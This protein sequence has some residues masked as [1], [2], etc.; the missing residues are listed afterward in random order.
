[1]NNLKSIYQMK[2]LKYLLIIPVLFSIACDLEEDPPFLDDTLYQD[3][4]SAEAARDG[5]YQA[6][7][8]YNT[9][10]RRLFI[11]NLYSGIMFTG[12]GGNRVT[13]RDMS[14]LCSLKPGLHMD[15]DFMWQGL[16]QAIARANGAIANVQIVSSPQ[17]QDEKA[18]NDVAGHAYFVRAWAYFRLA[19][20]WGD[21]PLWLELPSQGN[22]NK[23][24]SPEVDI[25]NQIIADLQAASSLLNGNAGVGY[26]KQYA[27]NMLL[28][29]VY[30]AIATNSVLQSAGSSMDYWNMAYNEGVKAYGQY[31]L[32]SDY[33]SLFTVQ[34]ENSSES[35]FE[36][37]ISQDAANSQM[38]RNFT[39]W[40][41]KAGMHF[42]W[43]RVTAFHHDV[44][45]KTYGAGQSWNVNNLGDYPDKRYAATYLYD[46]FR[47]DRPA[48]RVRT[49][50]SATW[51]SS[52]GNS[53]PYLF[54]WTEK[55][56]THSNQ[57]NSQNIVDMRYAE[58]LLMLAEISNEI[59]NG[60]EMTYL[61]PVLDRAGVP[62]R[63]EFTSGQ[64]SFRDAIM[65]EYKFEL[66]GEGQDSF[67]NRRRGL[68]Y[69]LDHTIL[70]HNNSIGTKV[71]VG[72]KKYAANRE[73]IF[74]TDPNQIMK[75]QIPL[76]EINT[77]ELIN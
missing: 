51:R 52:F 46:Y 67:H 49:Y 37:Q 50:P 59:G 57:Y 69:F 27:A 10:E 22:T 8:G 54:K 31:S 62:V 1:M 7:T 18:F 40:K 33:G 34:G 2:Y 28:S 17:T 48:A 3:V 65:Q 21:V 11:E 38:G 12:K 72:A 70:P 43:F 56:R 24:L 5:I 23:A 76:S 60:Q 14:T 9:Q 30:M 13:T 68:Q 47:Y 41:Y 74:S 15:A 35:I 71:A 66:I 42:G 36:L 53:H 32:V 20:L 26:P 16:Y 61:K 6:L 73:V 77:N 75:L 19:R 44:H 4:Q 64:A 63:S 55:D 45:L 29:K 58:L 39:P 25:Y